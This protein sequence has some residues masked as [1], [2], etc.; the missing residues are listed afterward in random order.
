MPF[1]FYTHG[2]T[3]VVGFQHANNGRGA[4]FAFRAHFLGDGTRNTM[5]ARASIVF[6]RCIMKEYDGNF[7]FNT[8]IDGIKIN[9]G[10]IERYGRREDHLSQIVV[11]HNL[12]S[13]GQ[14]LHL[15]MFK[16]LVAA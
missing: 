14:L 10:L 9:A 12:T 2:W 8:F 6:E 11:L 4:Y 7:T 13:C 15:H 5:F 1:F 16:A 3:W